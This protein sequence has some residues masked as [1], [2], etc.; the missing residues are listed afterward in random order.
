[1]RGF[2][3]S[4]ASVG[5][6]IIGGY[7][8]H[9][10]HP[11]L[12]SETLLNARQRAVLE[13]VRSAEY[14]GILALPTD[15]PLDSKR[16]RRVEATYP[17]MLA[18]PDA[19]RSTWEANAG[20][21][22]EVARRVVD[23]GIERAYLV[24]AGDSLAVMMAARLALE[25]MLGVPCEPMQS[26]EFAYYSQHIT[27][28][29]LVLALSSSGETTRT[30]EAILVAQHHGALTIAF[31]NTQG[32]TLDDECQETLLVR[33]TRVGW[34][35]QSSSAALAL[36]LRLAIGVGAER[37]ARGSLDLLSE[38]DRLPDLMA[39]A[40]DVSETFAEE[41]A[42][43]EVD[44]HMYLFSAGG[45]NWSSAIVGAAKVKECTPDHALAIQVEEYHHYNSQKPGEPLWLFAPSGPTVPRARETADEARRFGGQVYVVTSRGE[46]A[47]EN[48]ANEVLH[49]P[50]ISESLSPLLYFVSA[51]F[52]GYHLA[53]AKFS[54]AE[55]GASG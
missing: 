11:Q 10:K 27:P 32:S 2:L 22:A 26:L 36:I 30:I 16:R 1:M 53:M 50:A 24:G 3:R 28:R 48:A 42:A 20:P 5:Q 17:E 34:P 39:H 54:A 18:Q 29:T 45:P 19:I 46:D 52:V 15:D 38:L 35:T 37:S 23:L 12:D 8:G 21:L 25:H 6:T 49:L 40:L 55:V 51:Q 7:F 13:R 43:R 44:R 41:V 9:V 47:F 4:R 14:A 33:A 31:T